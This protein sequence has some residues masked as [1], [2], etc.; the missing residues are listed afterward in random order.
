M[1]LLA[2]DDE[3]L[4]LLHLTNILEEMFPN[5]TV[6]GFSDQIEAL[7]FAKE[8]TEKKEQLEFL[9][10]DIEMYGMSGIELA[11]QFKDICPEVKIL[12]VTGHDNYALEAF[13]LHAR[14]YILKPVTR[15][16]IEEE[17]QNIEGYSQL[18]RQQ[19]MQGETGKKKVTVRTFGNFDI[20]AG[21]EPL[22][23]S[24]SKAKELLAFLVDKK[25]TG[26]NTAEISS[27]LWEDKAY[28]RSLRNQTQT[29][30]SQ[31]MRNLKA[32]GI[33]DCVIKKWNYL[34]IDPE[35]IDCDYYNFLAG[36]VRAINSYTGEYM[37]NYS[38]AEF[39]TAYLDDMLLKER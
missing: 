4:A 6:T 22:Q 31:M 20:Y 29:V 30:I 8:L 17:M 16:L 34:A 35:R 10:L 24:R 32:A 3:K 18:E 11:R 9:F 39:T 23:F 36:D 37:S 5:D 7:A 12:F 1:H 21:D 26:V 33:E 14:G 27:I 38:W 2:V 13:R 15:E 19:R 28:D 25:G